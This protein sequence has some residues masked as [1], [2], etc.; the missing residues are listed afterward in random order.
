MKK[1]FLLMAVLI[2]LLCLLDYSNKGKQ[3]FYGACAFDKVS[4]LPPESSFTIDFVNKYFKGC[5][6][7][8]EPNLFKIGYSDYTLEI[9]SPNYVE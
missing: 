5:K 1:I 7:T 4:Y 3:D 9:K 2:L 8:I 6:Y